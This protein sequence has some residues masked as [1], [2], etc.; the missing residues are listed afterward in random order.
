MRSIYTKGGYFGSNLNPDFLDSCS[1][2]FL[3]KGL[4]KVYLPSGFPV[5]LHFERTARNSELKIGTVCAP[6]HLLEFHKKKMYK[7]T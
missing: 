1:K 7:M 2:R 4:Q 6:S 5:I 3:G